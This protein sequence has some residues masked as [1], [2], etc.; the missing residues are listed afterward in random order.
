[1]EERVKEWVTRKRKEELNNKRTLRIYRKY[2]KDIQSKES[3]M[4]LQKHP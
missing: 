3:R 4:T 1:M 2:K